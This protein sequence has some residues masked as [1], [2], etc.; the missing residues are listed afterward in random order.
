MKRKHL[1]LLAL[2]AIVLGAI[3]LLRQET[4]EENSPADTLLLPEEFSSD[5]VYSVQLE[6]DGR[7]ITLERTAKG[8]QVK[9]RDGYPADYNKLRELFVAL[10]DARAARELTLDDTQAASLEL[11]P[12]SGAVSVTLSDKDGKE[13]R[14]LLFGKLYEK[15]GS[16]PAAADPFGMGGG[17]GA[18]GRYL[19]LADGRSV[20]VSKTFS[21]V[22]SAASEW[23]DQ[24]F[25]QVSGLKRAVLRKNGKT[26][27]ELVEQ[28][29]PA[30]L[31]PT[32]TV[33]AGKEVDTGKVD[34]FKSAFSW[35]RFSDVAKAAAP[36]KEVPELELT[37]AD[38]FVY[39]LRPTADKDGKCNVQIAVR[40]D[41]PVT[42]EAG[43]E[44]KPEEKEKLDQEFAKTAPTIS[45]RRRL[46]TNVFPAG[47]IR[48]IR[49]YWRMPNSNGTASSV[50]NRNRK[51][52]RTI[53]PRPPRR[54]GEN[55]PGGEPVRS[56]PAKLPGPFFF[57]CVYRWIFGK[58]ACG[59]RSTGTT[60]T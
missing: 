55:S 25:F 53:P 43:K 40:Y 59:S 14:R 16:A 33:P 58:R 57:S 44:E 56:V 42:R 8:W 23:L 28:G 22:D 51:K 5:N 7:S 26:E 30:A 4:A 47:P 18:S 46:S 41:G 3:Y 45:K 2:V 11:T 38:N 24:E 6:K 1:I 9:E 49:A 10:C 34:S 60:A 12:A 37:D 48:S 31:A 32:G 50:K 54:R 27:W 36:G 15:A 17:M 19:R 52:R 29:S 13:L 20:L 21:E 35:L 39:T